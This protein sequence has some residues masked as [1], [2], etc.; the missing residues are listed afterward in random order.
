MIRTCSTARSGA[1]PVLVAIVYP[2]EEYPQSV[3]AHIVEEGRHLGIGMAGVLQH[4]V[5]SGHCEVALE[6]LTTGV[7]TCIF[8]NRGKAARGCR[9]DTSALADVTGVVAN[10]LAAEPE[11][12]ILNKFGKS[13][14]EG[15]GMLDLIGSAL[16][17]GCSVLIGVP[18]RNLD[19][20]RRFAG[21]L[22]IEFCSETFDA[23]LWLRTAFGDRQ[24]RPPQ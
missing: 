1:E 20:W 11:I 22:S 7:R 6:E 13:E 9:L 4:T 14:A 16:Q 23:K 5:G 3:L 24:P 12:L 19:A 21:D 18:A 8:D 2:D 17:R 10:S 15:G